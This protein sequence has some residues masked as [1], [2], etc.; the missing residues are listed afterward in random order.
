MMK[1][2]LKEIYD[3]EFIDSFHGYDDPYSNNRLYHWMKAARVRTFIENHSGAEK[4]FMDAGAGRGPYTYLARDKFAKIFCFEFDKNE[5][6]NA[7]KNICDCAEINFQEVDLTTIPLESGTVDVS[8]CSEVLEHIMDYNL[9]AQELHRVTKKGGY[10]LLSM[11]N[12][13][14][15][16]YR[17]IH[18]TSK[19]LLKLKDSEL[20]HEQWE[21]LRHQF[22]NAEDIDKIAVDAG[23]TILERCSVNV[24]PIPY[25]LRKLLMTRLSGVFKKYIAVDH[26]LGNIFPTWGSFYFITLR[27]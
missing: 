26:F 7:K 19:D 2:L 16:F 14:S 18:R 15:L 11:P 9:A 1:D 5:L 27:K 21:Y 24:L 13:R 20:T 3:M 22:F 25:A 23:F 10:L 17:N 8:V 12:N 4:I 6:M